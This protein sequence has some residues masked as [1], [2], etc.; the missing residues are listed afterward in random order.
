MKL[1]TTI[2]IDATTKVANAL[3]KPRGASISKPAITPETA[4]PEISQAGAS[5]PLIMSVGV[6]GRLSKFMIEFPSWP[7]VIEENM[8]GTMKGMNAARKKPGPLPLMSLG[9]ANVGTK[10]D[11]ATTTGIA[12]NLAR[13]FRLS[14]A[15]NSFIAKTDAKGLKP[16][17]MPVESRGRYSPEPSI[18]IDID[19][20]TGD[21]YLLLS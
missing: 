7:M 2:A 20:G 6:I 16:N 12:M 11:I 15:L 21:Q 18:E 17:P 1:L 8:N 14:S 5:F 19:I 9:L 4:M 13:S 10:K 3:L